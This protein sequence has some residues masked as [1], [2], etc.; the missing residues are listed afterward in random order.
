[1]S[2][3]AC[4]LLRHDVRPRWIGG[5]QAAFCHTC[6]CLWIPEPTTPAPAAGAPVET[7]YPSGLVARRSD[8]SGRPPV[9]ASVSPHQLA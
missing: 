9:P 7:P 8:R 4:A 6:G 2:Q 3:A 5:L 1:M